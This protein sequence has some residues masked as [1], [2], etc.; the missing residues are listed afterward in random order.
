MKSILINSILFIYFFFLISSCTKTENIELHSNNVVN[1]PTDTIKELSFE[2]VNTIPHSETSFTQGL[3]FYKGYLYEGTGLEGMSKLQKINPETG[4]VL[5]SIDLDDNI[6]GEGVTIFNDKIYQ[7][8]WHNQLCFVYDM[9]FN[10]LNEFK[11]YGEC[12][13]ITNNDSLLIMSDGSAYLRFINPNNFTILNNKM[14]DYKGRPLTNLNELEL[15]DDKIYANIWGNDMIVG[16]DINTGKVSEQLD[17]SSLHDIV[18][19]EARN[20]DVTNGIAYNAK[21]N[22]FYITGKNW[23]KIFEIQIK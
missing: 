7:V 18:K 5:K 13:G 17:V 12:W 22:T 11:Y 21:K 10:K 2:V 8:T 4:K 3:I 23:N 6:F 14:V 19:S 20:P 9:D 1:K 15:V 16:I